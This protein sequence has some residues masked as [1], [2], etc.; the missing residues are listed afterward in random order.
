LFAGA[1]AKQKR[2]LSAAEIAGLKQS[3]ANY[4]EYM[5]HYLVTP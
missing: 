1:P 5:K 4:L 2:L 3:A